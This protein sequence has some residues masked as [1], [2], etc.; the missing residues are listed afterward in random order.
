MEEEWGVLGGGGRTKS[1]APVAIAS[2]HPAERALYMYRFPPCADRRTPPHSVVRCTDS[3]LRRPLERQRSSL[4]PPLPHRPHFACGPGLKS[5]PARIAPRL[6][7][8][9]HR[10]AGQPTGKSDGGGVG[11]AGRGRSNKIVGPS[12]HRFG[13]SSGASVVY[14]PIPSLRRPPNGRIP[15]YVVPIPTCADRWNASAVLSVPRFLTVRT[16]VV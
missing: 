4:R 13:S 7:S 5:S 3:H 12:C 6:C 14:V 16:C 11:G 15:L 1:W 8:R 9:L 2:A 10:A